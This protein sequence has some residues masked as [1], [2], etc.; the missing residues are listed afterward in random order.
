[1]EA[2]NS[3]MKRHEKTRLT[4]PRASR[5]SFQPV[6]ALWLSHTKSW[7]TKSGTE[8]VSGL[9]GGFDGTEPTYE[10]TGHVGSNQRQDSIVSCFGSQKA[11]S[12]A[13]ALVDGRIG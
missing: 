2:S 11:L 10:D 1:M 9:S 3:A 8:R 5:A 4:M 13:A 7:M 6:F 12:L